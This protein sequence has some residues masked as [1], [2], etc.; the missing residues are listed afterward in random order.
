MKAVRFETT[1]GIDAIQVM[2][3]ESPV[4]GA[5]E[6]LVTTLAATINPVDL[7]AVTGGIGDRMPGSAP[8]IAGW[9]LAGTVTGVGDGVDASLLGKTV[10]GFSQWFRTANGTQVS[11]V[12][13]PFENVAIASGSLKPAE[14]TTFG[15]NGL[16]ALHALNATELH[17]GQTVIVAGASGGVGA[18]VAEIAKDRG[19]TVIPVGRNTDRAELAKANADAVVNS[20][21]IDESVLE[22]VKDGGRAI[23]VTGAYEAVRGIQ[24]QRVGVQPDKAGLEEIVRLAESGVLGVRLGKTFPVDAAQDA[25]RAFADGESHDRVVITL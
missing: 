6:V 23:S 13:L 10:L 14:L 1:T 24:S 3:V 5:G 19:L 18:F 17:E 8:W 9:D 22:G 25:Y 4:P 15:L 21:P 16:T 7:N 20:G 2:D 12:V 11:E